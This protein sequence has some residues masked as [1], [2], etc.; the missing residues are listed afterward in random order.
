MVATLKDVAQEVEL[1]IQ[2][3][4]DILN[5]GDIRY[6]EKTRQRVKA[7]AERI[8]Y[9]PNLMAQA[10]VRG[11]GRT[12][13]IGMVTTGYSTSV[14]AEKTEAICFAAARRGYHL[15]LGMNDRENGEKEI[16]NDFIGRRVEGLICMLELRFDPAP[17]RKLLDDGF[18]LVLLG[19]IPPEMKDLPHVEVHPSEGIYQAVSYLARL[20]HDRIAMAVGSHHASIPWGRLPGYARALRENAIQADE[21]LIMTS[22]ATHEKA[23]AFTTQVMRLPSRPT[24]IIYSND[25]MAMVGMHALWEMGLKV[26]QDVSGIG[27]DDLSFAKHI[28]PSLTTVRQP[29]EELADAVLDL[30]LER[31]EKRGSANSHRVLIPKLVERESTG[32]VHRQQNEY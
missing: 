15:Y 31:I 23:I 20:G 6:S 5:C 32:P 16:I 1:S 21:R 3:V 28:R 30:L 10:M 12:R 27:Y 9:Q 14:S 11:R 18:A 22:E 25:E 13:T 19:I 26:P 17:Y 8:G 4:S 7:V 29:R 2:T 24:A